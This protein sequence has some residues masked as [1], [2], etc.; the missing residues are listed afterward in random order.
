MKWV[1]MV[2]GT[3]AAYMWLINWLVFGRGAFTICYSPFVGWVL[4]TF[5]PSMECITIG[6]RCYLWDRNDPITEQRVTHEKFHYTNQWREY[7]LTFLPRYFYELWKYGYDKSPMENA[8]RAA[9][10]EPTR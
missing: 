5:A 10:G 4:R 7:P 6:A 3:L 2:G 1:Y 9:A 8:A